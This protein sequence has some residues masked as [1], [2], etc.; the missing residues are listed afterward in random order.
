MVGVMIYPVQRERPGR[1]ST[2]TWPEYFPSP[3]VPFM[4]SSRKAYHWAG[5]PVAQET[6]AAGVV[7]NWAYKCRLAVAPPTVALL[8]GVR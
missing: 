4:M 5:V 7:P 8:E 1:R 2:W 6:S 3:P